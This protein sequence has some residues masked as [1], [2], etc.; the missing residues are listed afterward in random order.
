[1]M[2]EHVTRLAQP[3]PEGLVFV[4]PQGTPLRRENFRRRTWY[5][6][7]SRHRPDDVGDASY[8]GG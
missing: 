2:V 8:T 4:I 5:P 3:G 7:L 6:A 1:L